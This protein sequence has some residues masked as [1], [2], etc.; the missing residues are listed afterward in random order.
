MARWPDVP[1]VFGWLALDARGRWLLKGE[2]I[3]NRAAVDF[4]ARNYAH[5]EFGRWY[6]QN[7]PQRVF[8]D[9]KA[10]PWVFRL[11]DDG[12]LNN[13]VGQI[14]DAVTRVFMDES[15]AVVLDTSAGV[16]LV[17]DRDLEL[18]SCDLIAATG[19]ELDEDSIAARVDLIAG[20]EAADLAMRIHGAV[21]P[22]EFMPAHSMPTKFNFVREPCALEGEAQG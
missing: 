9:L 7:G 4:I 11:H 13:H 18:L 14:V 2:T 17:D 8:V 16:G 19:G 3:A 15:G 10:T 12:Q 20:G 5:D 21:L 6:F 1:A 22:L